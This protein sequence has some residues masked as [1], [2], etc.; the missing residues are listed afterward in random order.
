MPNAILAVAPVTPLLTAAVTAIKALSSSS[1]SPM[2][3]VFSIRFRVFYSSH[4][5]S[6]VSFE[7]VSGA[8]KL[9]LPSTPNRDV[10][11]MIRGQSAAWM[12]FE[13]E[14][15]NVADNASE[16]RNLARTRPDLV[17]SLREDLD[18][19]WKVEP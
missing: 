7:A 3:R 6:G 4:I 2:L 8:W 10:T 18:R 1:V 15:F 11:L 12:C 5:N 9:I 13:P 14:L 16:L 17:R 19:W